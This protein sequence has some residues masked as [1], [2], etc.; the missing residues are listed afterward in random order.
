MSSSRARKGVM[1]VALVLA[2]ALAG[3]GSGSKSGGSSSAAAT[4][5]APA[6]SSG[7]STASSSSSGKTYNIYYDTSFIGNGF[8]VQAINTLKAVLKKGPLAGRANLHVVVSA[9][10]TP[11]S[12][13]AS[14]QN[15]LKKPDAIIIEPS[16]SSA[17]A[18]VIQQACN[19][20]IVVGVW[21]SPVPNACTYGWFM[22]IK[23]V[24]QLEAQWMAQTLHGKGTVIQDQGL[25]GVPLA[26]L[27]IQGENAVFNKYPGIHLLKFYSQ[28]ASGPTEQAVSALLASHPE[29]SGVAGMAFI[30]P[31]FSAFN[32][33]HRKI[34]PMTAPP[35]NGGLSD[36]AKVSGANCGLV[37]WP[38]Y[39]DAY[40]LRTVI[41]VLDG[42]KEPHTQT[43]PTGCYTSD[44]GPSGS[45]KCLQIDK[46]SVQGTSPEG[47]SPVSPPWQS[48]A[49]TAADVAG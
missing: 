22:P 42:K 3:C 41:D 13:I 19:Q 5:A 25:A 33:A 7:G 11:A 21:D 16:V 8:R 9:Q 28:F 17:L 49:L 40:V 4:S 10:N 34:V 36:C 27:W 6:A 43:I 31:V 12:Q 14:L 1:A 37:F 29:V 30:N 44:G 18:P 45:T 38:A 15:I 35:Y 20:H 26:T 46:L 2:I 39:Q 48:P 32:N 24:G 23:E 47:A